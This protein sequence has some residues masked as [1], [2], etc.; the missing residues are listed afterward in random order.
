MA[1][2]TPQHSG[3]NQMGCGFVG[4]MF[5]RK[6]F[7]R[8]RSASTPPL[9][10]IKDSGSVRHSRDSIKMKRRRPS[11]GDSSYLNSS[12]ISAKP[13]PP[14]KHTKS[15]SEK[16][17]FVISPR[18]SEDA[19]KKSSDSSAKLS[20]CNQ[21]P[22]V[23]YTK[24]LKKVPTFTESE[25]SMRI[26]VRQKSTAS[27][28]L[29]RAS[30][31]NG[32][33][34]GHLGN[35][36]Q[37]GAKASTMAKI[38]TTMNNH[39]TTLSKGS[40]SVHTP[41][42][43]GNIVKKPSGKTKVEHRLDSEMLKS[44]G[45]ENYKEGR[46]EEAIVLYAQAIAQ[47]PSKASYYSNKSAALI[48]LGR[49]IEA[50]FDCRVAIRINPMYQRAHQRLA[51]LYLRLGEADKALGHYKQLGAKADAR[52][53]S[54]AEALKMHLS[55]SNEARTL[56]DW[57]S[58][59]EESHM[60]ISSGADSS[61]QIFALKAEALL[62]L[63]KHQEAYSIIQK[64]PNYDTNLCI[65]FFGAARCSDLLIT[66]A[67]VYMAAGRFE[68]AVAAAQCA[69]KLDPT[70]EAKATAER[71]LA[72]ASARS[73]GNQ[74]FKASKFTDALKVYTE[75]LQHQALNSV[76]L[77][78]R[79]AC[80]SKLG[81]Y[82]KSVEDC[83]AA[84]AL[85]PSYAK[86]RLRRADCFSKLERW[87]ASVG[88]YEILMKENPKD[89]DVEKALYV[90]QAHAQ[91]QLSEDMKTLKNNASSNLV[92]ISSK[93]HF[94]RFVI[95]PGMSVVL[96]C[97]KSSHAR[98]FQLMEQVCL[99]F[100]S[101]NFLKVEVEDNPYIMQLEDVNSVPA[102]KI[103]KNGSTIKEISGEN[104]ESLESSVKMISCT[105]YN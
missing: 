77:C 94:R 3:R 48:G 100:P 45:N 23:G 64:G 71:A 69:A 103:Y 39:D 46:Y 24:W 74:L 59:E 6:G 29:Y 12:I 19:R 68:E 98:L 14:P 56:R 21:V 87:D 67:Q 72:L 51:K 75:G 11:S 104:F 85:R 97:N 70:E 13:P 73:E 26:A 65:Q 9:P 42:L 27:G 4:A 53:V 62:N 66:R 89:K 2:Q 33:L 43:M 50:V 79:A 7:V 38:K 18:H 44:M 81:D 17:S 99:R 25:L 28:I 58:V 32:M 37:G 20:S 16:P 91:K 82:E 55:K 35:L 96:F 49:L 86:A 30:S 102:F 36:K 54:L 31:N 84:L 101:V 8:P 57:E 47:D 40:S 60:A 5:Q 10:A 76:L 34:P 90:A 61:P 105:P 63:G 78:N 83:T 1:D 52:E 41:V 92:M 93:E 88:D 80:L 95:A 15:P 22:N